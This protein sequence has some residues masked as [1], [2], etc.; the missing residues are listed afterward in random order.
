MGA[1]YPIYKFYQ[2]IKYSHEIFNFLCG[3]LINQGYISINN[4][5]KLSTAII[6]R[7]ADL[8]RFRPS[9]HLRKIKCYAMQLQLWSG[10]VKKSDNYGLSF[11]NDFSQNIFR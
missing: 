6:C 3:I 5:R 11:E 4:S 7:I 8:Q 9:K 10:Q 1:S 2:N